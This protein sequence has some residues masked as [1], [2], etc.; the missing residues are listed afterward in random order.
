MKDKQIQFLFGLKRKRELNCWLAF[1]I[2]VVGYGGSAPSP[3][4]AFPSIHLTNEFQFSS[5]WFISLCPS[6]EGQPTLLS[7]FFFIQFFSL[8]INESEFSGIKEDWP[9]AHNQP[10]KH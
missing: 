1:I 4:A 7:F 5:L 9:A 6:E 3:Q 8:L 10:K 2:D